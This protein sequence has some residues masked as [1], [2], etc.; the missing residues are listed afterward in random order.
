VGVS[1]G[2]WTAR[3]AV[4]VVAL[5]A[6]LGAL[7]WFNVLSPGAAGNAG[8]NPQ[9]VTGDLAA[10]RSDRPGLRV[11]FVGN[12]FTYFNG[13]PQMVE[14]LAAHDRGARA[15]FVGQFAPPGWQLSWA[16]GDPTLAH[17]IAAEHWDDVVLQEQSQML[18]WAPGY[19]EAHT[20]PAAA[21]LDQMARRSGAR[22]VLYMTWG[23]KAG[24]P[25]AGSPDSY[26][27]MQARLVEGYTEL[28]ARLHAPVAAVGLAWQRALRKRPAE[29]LWGEDG[30]HPSLVGSYLAA[31]V[32][33][34][35]LAHRDPR[36]SD[37]T[38]GLPRA[39]ARRLQRIAAATVGS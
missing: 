31:C 5:A 38:A 22:T 27:A 25:V 12:S 34:A 1:R 36:H 11:L 35:R 29:P 3:N 8:I 15:L 17:A 39:E 21:R 23:Y 2:K 37:F 20:F 32:L 6:A 16:A 14:Q 33:Y 26:E 4:L 28:G 30:R 19:R 7:L 13:M 9:M 18:S 24:D 10:V